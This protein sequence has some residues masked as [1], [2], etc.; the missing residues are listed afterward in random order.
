MVRVLVPPAVE[1][2]IERI[3]DHVARHDPETGRS[4]MKK[5]YGRCQTLSSWPQRGSPYDDRYRYLLE[6]NYRIF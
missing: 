2:D 3:G 6:G 4:L 1:A 5:L